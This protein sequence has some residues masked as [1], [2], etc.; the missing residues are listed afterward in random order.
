[1]MRNGTDCGKKLLPSS[2]L[3]EFLNNR[4]YKGA[5]TLLNFLNKDDKTFWKAYC[6]FHD[7]DFERAR[8]LYDGILHA[9]KKN[10]HVVEPKDFVQNRDE[11]NLY[12][13]CCYFH[14]QK[15]DEAMQRISCYTGTSS[16]KKRL[17]LHLSKKN[18]SKNTHSMIEL[19]SRTDNTNNFKND[20]FHYEMSRAAILYHEGKCQE[21][22]EAYNKMLRLH[23]EFVAL[24]AFLAMCYFKLVSDLYRDEE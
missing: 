18:N 6:S 1:M 2:S 9:D 17:Q 13:A 21:A 3:D 11:I 5:S 12:I 16:L 7:R 15:F 10:A 23:P 24:N 20:D 14:L 8:K 22:A 19:S 4:D